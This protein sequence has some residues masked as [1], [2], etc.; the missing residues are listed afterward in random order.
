MKREEILNIIKS[1][2]NSKGFYGRLYFDLI[3]AKNNHPEEYDE[4]MTVLENKHFSN[5]VDL[6]L[7]LEC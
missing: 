6:I 7:Y 1:L 3:Y 2:S 4:F 5:P